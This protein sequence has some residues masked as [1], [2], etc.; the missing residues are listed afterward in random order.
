V[1]EPHSTKEAEG[2]LTQVP[3]PLDPVL[4]VQ[5]L[6]AAQEAPRPET[7]NPENAPGPLAPPTA[8]PHNTEAPEANVSVL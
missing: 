7:T 8:T 2:S 3:D 5:S 1:F 6:P 4:D